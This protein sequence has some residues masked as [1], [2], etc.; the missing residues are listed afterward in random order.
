MIKVTFI[1][2]GFN[3]YHSVCDA[4]ADTGSQTKWLNIWKL[5]KSYLPS[6]IG[7]E[8]SLVSIYYFSAF[9]KHREKVDPKVTERHKALLECFEDTGIKIELG[10]FKRKPVKCGICKRKFIKHEEKETDVSIAIKLF[11]LFMKDECDIAI[12]VTGDSDLAPAVK[13]AQKLFP[14]KKTIF[15]FP[16]KRKL[17]ELSKLAPGSFKIIKEQYLKF[18]FP[19]PYKLKNGT[20]INKPSSW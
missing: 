15:A 1:I 6:Q 11:E 3:L 8:A 5:C 4:A 7:R 20:L 18:Q 16:Y 12:L 2:D 19:D 14:T 9:A 10:R 17:R 13:K